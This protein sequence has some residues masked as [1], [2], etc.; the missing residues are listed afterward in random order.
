MDEERVNNDSTNSTDPSNLDRERSTSDPCIRKGIIN[1]GRMEKRAMEKNG[2]VMSATI[3]RDVVHG[4]PPPA[5]K[6]KFA[7][8]IGKLFRPWKWRKRKKSDR[9]I[10]TSQSKVLSIIIH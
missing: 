9:F 8:S 10:A 3:G 6:N 5:R 4:T 1:G 7:S 2:V